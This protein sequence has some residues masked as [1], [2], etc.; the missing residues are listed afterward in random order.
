VVLSLGACGDDGGA[1]D[2]TTTTVR[3]AT[4]TTTEIVTT[5]SELALSDLTGN[6]D[7]GTLQLI[8]TDQGEYSVAD[9]GTTD[10]DQAR[11][12]GFVARNGLLFNFITGTT[13]ECPGDTGVY[14]ASI[15][16]EELTLTLVEDPCELR[17][18][19]FEDVFSLTD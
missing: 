5:T 9:S 8:V 19:G 4:T 15:S 10:P 6:W 18:S 7:N 17:V 16:E 13:R 3:E 12:F 2:S 1:V 11:I 14:E